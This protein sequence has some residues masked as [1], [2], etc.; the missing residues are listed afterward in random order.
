MGLK[1]GDLAHLSLGE[2]AAMA[3][4]EGEGTLGLP[5]DSDAVFTL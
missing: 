5:A 3:R 4:D 1:L 2:L